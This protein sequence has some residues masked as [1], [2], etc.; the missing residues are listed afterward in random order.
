[1]EVTAG[2]ACP[3]HEKIEAD[4]ARHQTWIGQIQDNFN[5]HCN[6]GGNHIQR[7]EFEKLEGTVITVEE[8]QKTLV[9]VVDRLTQSQSLLAKA[10]SQFGPPIIVALVLLAAEYLFG[11][12]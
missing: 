8:T 5:E 3:H 2:V 1:M 9:L 4:V 7:R 12:N 10:W 11:R 6:G